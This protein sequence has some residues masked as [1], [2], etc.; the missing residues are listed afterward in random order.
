MGYNHNRANRKRELVPTFDRSKRKLLP[1]RMDR[2]LEEGVL[3]QEQVD[4]FMVMLTSEDEEL[5]DLACTILRKINND[6]H[7]GLK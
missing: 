7:W 3:T 4:R 5:D 1:F 6:R 2:L